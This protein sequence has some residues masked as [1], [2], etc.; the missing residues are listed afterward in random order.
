MRTTWP[1][2]SPSP[3]RFS[4][5]VW[6]SSTTFAAPSI[7]SWAKKRPADR[8]PLPRVLV[9]SASCP[10]WWWPSWCCRTRP[11]RR[12]APTAL[13]RAP[14]ARRCDDRGGVVLGERRSRAGA[15]ADAARSHAAGQDDD[16]VRA[17]AP[18]LLVDP[19][20]RARADRDHR[21][22]RADADDDAEHGQ[23][24]AQLVHAERAGAR[25]ARTRRRSR[26]V[27][28][29]RPPPPRRSSTWASSRSAAPTRRSLR[30]PSRNVR[31]RERT[32]AMSVLVGD[33]HDRDARRG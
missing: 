28:P 19:G 17:E 6:P 3:N 5:T 25:C 33:E 1:T 31:I 14:P 30:W 2:G 12:R 21:D 32:A 13:P 11:G 4:A 20:L 10:G 15:H 27:L 29:T 22:H 7:S 18:D 8:R 16:Q 23:D 26:R 24:A 9:G